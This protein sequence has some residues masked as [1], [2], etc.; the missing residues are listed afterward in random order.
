MAYTSEDNFYNTHKTQLEALNVPTQLWSSL[1]QQLQSRLVENTKEAIGLDESISSIYGTLIVVPHICQ[2]NIQAEPSRGL[3]DVLW[4]VPQGQLEE[5]LLALDTAHDISTDKGYSD[6]KNAVC[7]HAC[8]WA[9]VS[10][11]VHAQSIWAALLSPPYPKQNDE[12]PELIGPLQFYYQP[13]SDTAKQCSLYYAPPESPIQNRLSSLTLDVAPSY[14]FANCHDLNRAVRYVG[15]LGPQAAPQWALQAVREA[16]V[17]FIHEMHLAR[18]HQLERLPCVDEETTNTTT[19]SVPSN[20]KWKIYTDPIDPFKLKN[21]EGGL[22]SPHLELVESIEDADYIYSS[23]SLYSPS[24]PYR[25]YLEHKYHNQFPYEAAFC[26]KDHLGREI[27]KQHGLP[28]P[29]WAL[30]TYDLDVQ[31]AHFV[32]SSVQDPNA[33]WIIKPARGTRSQGHVV[34]RNMGHVI[35]LLDSDTAQVS[36]V[37]G[38]PKVSRVAQRYIVS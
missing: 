27:L 17:R 22:N 37:P 26:G 14:Y 33:M 36:L 15:L 7:S 29:S 28:R 16:H 32:A 10:L 18:Q 13:I 6:L 20:Q 19:P 21:K 4:H 1:E 8:L 3:W 31:L 34:T 5:V 2:W 24:C 35:R 23:L 25:T 38:I 30:E 11:Y 9:H 12:D